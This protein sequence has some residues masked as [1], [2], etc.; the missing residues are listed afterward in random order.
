M[1]LL[2]S[3]DTNG[4]GS[5]P[6]FRR[7]ALGGSRKVVVFFILASV[8]LVSFRPYA[9]SDTAASAA[10]AWNLATNGTMDYATAG[11]DSMTWGIKQV[12]GTII[13]DRFPGTFWW[14][15]LSIGCSRR[16]TS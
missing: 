5:S 10:V 1:N 7:Y 15:Y 6:S 4:S 16:P 14:P 2:E 13:T 9:M 12:D 3:N 11:F 8:Y